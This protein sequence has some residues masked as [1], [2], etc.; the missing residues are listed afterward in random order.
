MISAAE[1]ERLRT[2][3]RDIAVA[4]LPPETQTRREGQWLRFVG[5]GGL[6][7]HENGNWSCRSANKGGDQTIPLIAL[8]GKYDDAE[9]EKWAVA[10]LHSHPGLGSCLGGCGDDVDSPASSI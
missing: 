6:L 3:A 8:I 7:I 9:A 5:Q 4:L 2:W 1:S 10:W